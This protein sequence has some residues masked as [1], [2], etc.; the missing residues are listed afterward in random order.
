MS[1]QKVPIL[2]TLFIN[3]A[4]VPTAKIDRNTTKKS[5]IAVITDMRGSSYFYVDISIPK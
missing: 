1:L 5:K 4:S 3:I 2:P